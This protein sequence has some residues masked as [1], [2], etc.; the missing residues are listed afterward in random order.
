MPCTH[1]R[2]Y[3]QASHRTSRS[4]QVPFVAAFAF[5]RKQLFSISSLVFVVALGK[6]LLA[7]EQLENLMNRSDHRITAGTLFKSASTL[8]CCCDLAAGSLLERSA[9]SPELMAARLVVIMK[10]VKLLMT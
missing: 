6:P 7:H 4:W 9:F 5:S 10:A 8:S 2:Y 1:N 3:L